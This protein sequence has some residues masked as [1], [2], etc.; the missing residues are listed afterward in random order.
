M[1]SIGYRS[2]RIDPDLPFDEARG[3]IA[4]SDHFGRVAD[5]GPGAT[6]YASGWAKRG[7]V[8]VIVDTSTDAR[9]TADA[10]VQDIKTGAVKETGGEK[11]FGPVEEI[12]Q[13]RG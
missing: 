4:C 10:M 2:V 12:L 3:V 1:R 11:G 8:G 9:H 13:K 5:S 6:L 7:A